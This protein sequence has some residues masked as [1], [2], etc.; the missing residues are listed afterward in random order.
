MVDEAYYAFADA[1]FLA[2]VPDLPNLL[3]LRTLSKVGMAGI[4]LGYA[5][6]AP[7]WIA[8]LNKVRQPYNV[9]AL[10]QAAVEALLFDTDWI[11]EQALA[12]RAERVRQNPRWRDCRK[13]ACTRRRPISCWCA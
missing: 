5:V 8:E 6:A 12:I 13:S 2:R 3:V 7:A 10:T 1:S 11:A 9:N 4:R